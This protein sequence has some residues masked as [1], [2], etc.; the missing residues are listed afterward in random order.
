MTTSLILTVQEWNCALRGECGEGGLFEKGLAKRDE[1]GAETLG[2]ELR[3]IVEEYGSADAEEISAGATALRG[4]RFCMLIEPYPH[5]Q[6]TLRISL[7]KDGAALDEA[8]EERG[9]MQ[10]G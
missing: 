6:D 5:M 7:Y 2:P 1:N 8:L 9:N 3:L 4:G 10:D